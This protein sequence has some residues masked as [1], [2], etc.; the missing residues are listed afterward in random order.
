MSLSTGEW[1]T[2]GFPASASHFDLQRVHVTRSQMFFFS[3][4]F[5]L[6]TASSWC[7]SILSFVFKS[8]FYIL[9]YTWLWLYI[10]STLGIPCPEMT[11]C[12]WQDIKI[13]ELRN[14]CI[15]CFIK[16]NFFIFCLFFFFLFLFLIIKRKSWTNP[17]DK[18]SDYFFQAPKYVQGS[19][20]IW[21]LDQVS[22]YYSLV[23]FIC[24]QEFCIS[25]FCPPGSLC[26][27]FSSP[28][29][30]TN[31][32]TCDIINN[33]TLAMMVELWFAQIIYDRLA[34]QFQQLIICMRIL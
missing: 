21:S 5:V 28:S 27:M 13:Q 12:S 24:C 17:K 2:V 4:S 15:P 8:S 18:D 11:Q 9:K 23:C 3:V 25:I 19:L 14:L 20:F 7:L 22:N 33:Q 34:I 26:I 10:V 6:T 32:R 16:K 1:S 30:S 29:S 31:I